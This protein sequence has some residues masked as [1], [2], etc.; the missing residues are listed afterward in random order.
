MIL[1]QGYVI[2]RKSLDRQVERYTMRLVEAREIES[3]LKLQSLVY[4]GLANK[5]ILYKDTKL[6]MLE[7]LSQGGMIIGVFNSV[8]ELISY[9]YISFPGHSKKNL[10]YD[11]HLDSSQLNKV[12]HLETTL[13]SPD[14]RGNRLQS[15]TLSKA[16]DLIEP[17]KMKHL[18]CTVSPYNIFSLYIIMNA[19]L[20]IKAL[21]RKYGDGN[22]GV[23]RFILHKNLNA[24]D[25]LDRHFKQLKMDSI[26][27]QKILIEKGY[28]GYNLIKESQMIQYAMQCS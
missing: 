22:D 6:E 27:E 7:D 17:M 10:G 3:V 26:Q 4:D 16:I 21:K 19:G 14:Y 1:N 25:A 18:L 2:K 23:W 20:S 5:E 24:E 15:L 12:V 11:I 9:R 8:E 28:I 13:V